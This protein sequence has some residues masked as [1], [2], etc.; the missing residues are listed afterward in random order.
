MTQVTQAASSRA[1]DTRWFILLLAAGWTLVILAFAVWNL[2]EKQDLV[3]KLA[4]IEA[5]RAIDWDIVNRR[6]AAG[7]G[8]VYVPISEHTQPNPNMSHIPERDIVTPS[9]RTLTLMN[10]AY[11]NRQ[12]HE[13]GLQQY[14]LRSHITSLNPIRLENGPD[15][16]ERVQ[17][18]KFENGLTEVSSIETID[19]VQ[20]VRYMRVMITEESCLKCHVEQGN[21]VG[22]VRGGVSSSIPLS[23]TRFELSTRN[24]QIIIGHALMWILGLI[25]LFI[26]G[27]Y[28]LRRDAMRARLETKLYKSELRLQAAVQIAEDRRRDESLRAAQLRLVEHT[29]ELSTM[30]LLQK[31]LDEAEILTESTIG[32]FHYVKE[33]E[34][35]LHL[36]AWSTNTLTRMCTAES[37]GKHC[38]VE[39][40][41]VWID[42]LRERRPVIHNDYESLPHKK[43]LPEGHAPITRELVVPVMREGK[44]KAVLG[45]GNKSNDYDDRDVEQVQSLADMAWET[46]ERKL[47]EEELRESEERY[48]S[49]FDDALDMVHIVDTEGRITDANPA[50]LEKLGYSRD[51]YIG[52]HVKQIIHPDERE[53]TLTSLRTVLS[54]KNRLAYRTLLVTREG[55]NI[56]VE[57]NAFPQVRN[58]TVVSARAII[59]DI[60]DQVRA[61]DELR[62]HREHLED[63][64]KQRTAQLEA[65]INER[66]NTEHELRRSE[67]FS[68][69]LADLSIAGVY[70]YDLREMNTVYINTHYTRLTGHTLESLNA[71]PRE[72]L[73]E[74]IH[75]DDSPK[76]TEH[77]RQIARC[78]EGDILQMDYRLK[79][80]DG[81]WIYCKA[82]NSPFDTDENG[83]VTQLIGTFLDITT[84]KKN[85][86]LIQKRTIDL[87]DSRHA[88]L[89]LM[90]DAEIERKRA[91][92]A[93]TTLKEI[94][95]RYKTL[96]DSAPVGI[97]ES[98]VDGIHRYVNQSALEIMGLTTES[99]KGE[100]WSSTLHPD[101][102]DG[103]HRAWADF[104]KNQ[105]SYN[106]T[107][108]YLHSDGEV[109]W[110]IAQAQP[111][112]NE[113]HELLGFIGVFID[114]TESRR[115]TDEI[116]QHREHLEDLVSQRTRQL[117]ISS[118]ELEAAKESAENASQAKGQFLANM[119]HEIRTPM[120]AVLGYAQLLI[121]DKA[122]DANQLHQAKIIHKSGYHLLTLINDV[123]EMSKIEAG[124]TVLN[125]T[126]FNLFEMLEDIKSMFIELTMSKGVGLRFSYD[127]DLIQYVDTDF[128][129]VR[130]VVINLL[131]NAQKFTDT[132]HIEVRTSSEPVETG[133]HIVTISVE[134]TGCGIR[135]EDIDK[136]FDAFEQ[137]ESGQQ[138][139]GTGL[140]M[141]ISR[142]FA[143]SM[144]GDLTVT[145]DI[146]EGSCFIFTFSVGIGVAEDVE[147]ETLQPIPDGLAPSVKRR[148][149][150]IVDDIETNRNL[151]DSLLTTVGFSC[152]MVCT[153]EQAI[154]IHD[155]WQPDL[156]LM[157]L[158]MPGMGGREAIKQLRSSGSNA[159]IIAISA[160]VTPDHR[161]DVLKDGADAFIAKPHSDA[162]LFAIIGEILEIEYVYTNENPAYANLVE[163]LN[164]TAS[165]IANL[166]PGLVNE[167]RQT[168]IS[169]QINQ[170]YELINRVEDHSPEIAKQLR[171]LADDFEYDKL[172]AILDSG[173]DE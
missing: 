172:L 153:G 65:E 87:E 1:T 145:S 123:L 24:L 90:E 64:V 63:L 27:L 155:T 32:F 53:R 102:A 10:P 34:N 75:P 112:R 92:N 140:G 94:E 126:T 111:V 127:N 160:S 100:G 154:D 2:V 80:T 143:Q 54:G 171:L 79:T 147:E 125:L 60:T 11:M 115:A 7:H 167:L 62:L 101:E 46:A 162:E 121:R 71:I 44:I 149:V 13:I 59:R 40:A 15:P 135:S 29:G 70:I 5:K 116:Q 93:V 43:G 89:N 108:R 48:R 170:L 95:F 50:E 37:S 76:W 120:N 78:K 138:H 142:S 114:I 25:G 68:Q 85:E 18:Q 156:V 8:G 58:G 81:R 165:T 67:A 84:R 133:R 128:A 131:S 98:D 168:T 134:D 36:Q 69:K 41:G 144:G 159:S 113:E 6:W 124:R 136:I 55:T 82:Y 72:N 99:A 4:E 110:V 19:N 17:L 66:R 164:M 20:Y 45:I 106:Q 151:L 173:I 61:E 109:R 118:C 152:E 96:L 3:V 42:C 163:N 12:I 77:V 97:W 23:Q 104:I 26:G 49:L 91:E 161:R 14:N 39:D 86:K 51:E 21:L 31:T 56:D 88:A 74:L 28:V 47:T 9:G 141:P 137:S 35:G 105:D 107:N 132:G 52:M 22:E 146:G 150:L 30:E 169:A 119:S 139:G 166:P 103:L 33:D 122:L 129:K 130:Q 73:D 157:D 57:I 38:P 158:R 16:W 148:K 117:E 83:N